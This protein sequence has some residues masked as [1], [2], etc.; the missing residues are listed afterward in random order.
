[1]VIS[2][3]WLVDRG[4]W[5][6]KYENQ[7][8]KDTAGI[9]QYLQDQARA[10]MLALDIKGKNLDKQSAP[11]KKAEALFNQA[12]GA[13]NGWTRGIVLE[14]RLKRQIDVSV[15][16]YQASDAG[17]R[18]SAFLALDTDRL[19]RFDP[20]T[21]LVI[22]KFV[23]DVI[24]ILENQNDARV[25]RAVTVIETEFSKARWTTFEETTPKWVDEKYKA[26][27]VDRMNR[28]NRIQ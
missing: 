17:K 3:W 11:Y 4:S 15:A 6:P 19:L 24:Q 22:A 8:V 26:G 16:D 14:A 2:G 18:L 25:E 1:M 9:R 28:M 7:T 12:A 23:A 13:G 10:E 5:I 20:V 21:G 27:N